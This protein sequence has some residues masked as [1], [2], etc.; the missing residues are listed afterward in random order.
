MVFRAHVQHLQEELGDLERSVQFNRGHL[1]PSSPEKHQQN[2][3]R[4]I[5]LKQRVDLLLSSL[6]KL[7]QNS[8]MRQKQNTDLID[9]LKRA[10]R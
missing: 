1:I 4:E 5:Q 7:T 3:G 8:D 9:D 10:N 6:D 2:G